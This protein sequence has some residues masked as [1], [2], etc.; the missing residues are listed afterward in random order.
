MAPRYLAIYVVL[1]L[2]QVRAYAKTLAMNMVQTVNQPKKIEKIMINTHGV[3]AI[4]E[5]ALRATK[6][7]VPALH[8]HPL[9]LLR[10]VKLPVV[11]LVQAIVV[12]WE[13]VMGKTHNVRNVGNGQNIEKFQVMILVVQ[14]GSA[15]RKK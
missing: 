9:L 10:Q 1:L 15:Q 4:P 12:I 11:S 2:H 5:L 13:F 8:A 6:K 3:V 7:N 14:D